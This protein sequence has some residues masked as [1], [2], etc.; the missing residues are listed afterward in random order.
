MTQGLAYSRYS[1][2]AHL[3]IVYW[4]QLICHI[5]L[6]NTIHIDIC[7]Y[8][9]RFYWSWSWDGRNLIRGPTSKYN[10]QLWS[11]AHARQTARPPTFPAIVALLCPGHNTHT[12]ATITAWSST[13][14][15]SLLIRALWTNQSHSPGIY[16]KDWRFQL[17]SSCDHERNV[18][19][20]L[21]T[22]VRCYGR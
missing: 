11:T 8:L 2:N 1:I 9:A 4:T 6:C 20:E 16:N 22:A 17:Q 10:T 19:S 7:W 18:C 3:A 5:W 13:V 12:S 21:W 14:L 15:V